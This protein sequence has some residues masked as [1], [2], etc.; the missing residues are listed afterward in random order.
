MN[1][2]LKRAG[3][4]RE[5]LLKRIRADIAATTP[6]EDAAV[7]AAAN[8]DPDNPPNVVPKRIGRPPAAVT[9]ESITLRIDPD[10]VRRFK[11][12]G[13]GWQSRMNEALR[14]AIGL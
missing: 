9:K 6:E 11:A 5:A 2:P 1:K 12:D 8:A 13:P 4:Q 14:K 3:E 10:V 7:T